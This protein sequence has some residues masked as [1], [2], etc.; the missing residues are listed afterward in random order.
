MLPDLTKVPTTNYTNFINAAAL[1]VNVTTGLTWGADPNLPTTYTMQYLFNVQRVL[2]R[3]STLEIGYSGTQSR[4]VDNLTNQNAP[5]PGITAFATRAPY[6][7]YAGIQFLKADGVG[8]YFSIHFSHLEFQ[9]F[10]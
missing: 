4:K 5:I 3:S 7:E 2:G 1:P 10:R 6:P 8:N 9:S